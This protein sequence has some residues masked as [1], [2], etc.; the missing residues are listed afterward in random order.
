MSLTYA[1]LNL[2]K[3][4]SHWSCITWMW[5]NLF[6][7]RIHWN[8]GARDLLLLR[9]KQ[10]K[11]LVLLFMHNLHIHC[12]SLPLWIDLLNKSG[13]KGHGSPIKRN[14]DCHWKSWATLISPLTLLR[15]G[16]T[17]T[18]INKL[19]V[20]GLCISFSLAFSHPE[21]FGTRHE[22]YFIPWIGENS[23]RLHH[24]GSKTNKSN[25]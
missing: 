16:M 8:V 20:E 4:L 13:V 22:M 10:L 25:R 24:Q 19:P 2:D 23:G 14:F 3:S 21:L 18:K 7:S 6:C 5:C 1:P 12:C 9:G 15:H 17:G 11:A